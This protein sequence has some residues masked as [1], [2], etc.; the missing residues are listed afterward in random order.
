MRTRSTTVVIT[1]CLAASLFLASTANAQRADGLP[2]LPAAAGPPAEVQELQERAATRDPV[3]R[4]DRAYVLGALEKIDPG[5]TRPENLR[6]RGNRPLPGA[7]QAPR[8]ARAGQQQE[9][10]RPDRAKVPTRED[11][12]R[13]I[14]GMPGGPELLEKARRGG[15]NISSNLSRPDSWLAELNPFRVRE[16]RAQSNYSVV[17]TPQ[18]PKQSSPYASLK[19]FGA[20]ATAFS[21]QNIPRWTLQNYSVTKNGLVTRIDGPQAG[22]SIDIPTTGWYVLNYR[23]YGRNIAQLVHEPN[24]AI[25]RKWNYFSQNTWAN[26]PAVVHLSAGWHYLSFIVT[27]G[28]LMLTSV[29]IY[30]L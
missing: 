26:Y 6:R 8:E 20:S 25:V 15:A 5:S 17:L 3:R 19:A 14:R 21:S 12:L 28:S 9:R 4:I 7:A 27:S 18:N 16:A 23:G 10:D 30:S 11:L 29:S 13:E 1:G 2:R 24:P 22:L